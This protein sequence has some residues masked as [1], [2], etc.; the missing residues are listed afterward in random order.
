M[1]KPI[2]RIYVY[3]ELYHK[4]M[5]WGSNA[6]WSGKIQKP[7]NYKNNFPYYLEQYIISLNS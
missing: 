4:I 3:E 7:P 1:D 6:V 5:M 2:K